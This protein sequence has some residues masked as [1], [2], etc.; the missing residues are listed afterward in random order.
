MKDVIIG[1][2]I[3]GVILLLLSPYF[4]LWDLR[5]IAS[6]LR[7]ISEIMGKENKKP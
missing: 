5:D 3:A 6:E 1:L 4:C 2:I 7:K